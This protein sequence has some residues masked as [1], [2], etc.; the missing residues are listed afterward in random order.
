M[1]GSFG[2]V[3]FGGDA[4]R[5]SARLR[6]LLRDADSRLDLQPRRLVIRRCASLHHRPAPS[7]R[8][9]FRCA[10]RTFP[11]RPHSRRRPPPEHS[12]RRVHFCRRRL[13][14]D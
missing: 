12:K 1:D 13:L 6:R 10:R 3:G 14:S 5:R 8:E 9:P 11:H 2:R 4:L 7:G